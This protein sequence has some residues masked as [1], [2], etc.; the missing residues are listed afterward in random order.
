[1]FGI[2]YIVLSL[3]AGKDLA[4]ILLFTGKNAQEAG[5]RNGQHKA[6]CNQIWVLAAATFGMGTLVFGWTTYMISWAASEAGAKKPLIYG[7]TAVLIITAV[8][9]VLLYWK[10]YRKTGTVWTV[11]DRKLI[12]DSRA[13]RKECILF[14]FL[15]VFL[16]WIMF[17]VFYIRNGELYSG[18]SVYGDYAPHTAMMRSF[19]KGNNFPTEY[20]HFGGQDV[21]YHFMFQFLVG[22]L[23]F[24][25]IRLDFAYNIES[26]LA[27]LGFLMLLYSIAKRLTASLAAGIL[28]LVLFFFRSSLSFFHFVTEHLQAKDLWAT[29]RDNTTFIGYTT[30][31]NWGLWNF[32]VYLNQRHLAFGLLIVSLVIWL[33]MDWLDIGCAEEEKGIVWLRNRFFTKKAWKCIC[34]ENAL[35]AGMFLGLTS[36][37][38][39]AAV[40]GG[41]LILLGFAVFSDGKL[42]YLILAATSVI[43]SVLQ[44]RIFIWGEAVS[45]SLYWG[46]LSD[47]KTLWGVLWYLIQMSGIF[48][49]GAVVLVFL[50][51]KRQQRAALISFLFPAAFAFFVSLT[52]DIA[53]N[54]KY[55]MISYAFTAIFWAWA[56]MQLFQ[57]KIL[58]RIVA[59]LLAV[60]LTITGIYDFVVIIRNNG[61]GHRVSVNMNSDLTDWLEEHRTHEDLI[62]TPEYSINEVTMS[63]VMMYMGWPYYAWSA[64]YDTYYR[65]AQAKTIYSTINKEELKKLVKQEKITYILYEEGMEYEQQYCREETIASVYK[66][67]YETEDGRIRIYE[68]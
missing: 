60:C 44:T 42:D 7:N 9:L 63:G 5:S 32:N 28:T 34:P 58:H 20:P 29:L 36:F 56:L 17:Y 52:P 66:L 54:H 3:L 67:V 16:T 62:L 48:F 6:F 26:V 23:E 46:F 64:G 4:E 1:M 24:L 31:E 12:S 19:S 21:K 61:P 14:G 22:N 38:N 35:M 27:L 13:F 50:L 39:G 8:V 43:F 11:A 47:D 49:V 30:N 53:V 68:T 55:I 40:I 65:A 10:R 37:W 45:P 51:K 41:L 59:V 57:K 18:F 33:F 2:I 15:L 25:G